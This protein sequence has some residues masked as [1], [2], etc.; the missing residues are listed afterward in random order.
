MIDESSLS[1]QFKIIAKTEND[2]IM[3]I[4]H[5][6]Y[7][8]YGVQFHPESVLSNYGYRIISS[9]LNKCG[10]KNVSEQVFLNLETKLI[11]NFK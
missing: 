7:K 2:I 10:Y 9:F 11:E 5:K 3:G 1:T 8:I 6:K 4:E